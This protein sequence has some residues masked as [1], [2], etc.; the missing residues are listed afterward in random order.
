[1][2]EKKVHNNGANIKRG[3]QNSQ[4]SQLVTRT[5]LKIDATPFTGEYNFKRTIPEWES[6]A[7]DLED[8]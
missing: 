4:G 6:A 5:G 3:T 2:R 7:T 1:M 8:C